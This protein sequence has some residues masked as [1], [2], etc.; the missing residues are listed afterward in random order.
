MKIGVVGDLHITERAPSGR[1]DTCF[2]YTCAAKLEQVSQRFIEDQV[3]VVAMVG[4]LFDT[5]R[6]GN[7]AIAVLRRFIT[8]FD[9]PVITTLGQHDV[10]HKNYD[11][12]A[13]ESD[14][15]LLWCDNLHVLVG[16]QSVTIDGVTFAGYAI[17]EDATEDFLN[18]VDPLIAD[19]SMRVALV[20]AS[21][22]GT[23][24]EFWKGIAD[25]NIKSANWA[26]FGDIHEGFDPYVF[27]NA[28]KT[29]AFG[30]GS[31]LRMKRTETHT[32]RVAIVNTAER[33][34]EFFE[35]PFLTPHADAF[36][37]VEKSLVA[38]LDASAIASA[39]ME[40][41]EANEQ[42]ESC[43]ELVKK[44]GAAG[45]FDAAVVAYASMKLEEVQSNKR[46]KR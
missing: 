25:C 7:D 20:H 1:T 5:R 13:L 31:L 26:F 24:S 33:S 28:R 35:I 43:L 34:V 14:V 9:V 4:D 2:T 40:A 15:R 39:M 36:K 23:A 3:D 38:R 37:E 44:V 18:G 12:W 10:R 29:V 46:D 6:V 21:V 42:G 27:N 32:P 11:D 41:R 16:G 22:S 17:G 8:S 45:G 30:C 19:N